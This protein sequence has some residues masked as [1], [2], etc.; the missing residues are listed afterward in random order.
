MDDESFINFQTFLKSRH[1]K[2][3][4]AFFYEELLQETPNMNMEESENHMI[5]NVLSVFGVLSEKERK[6]RGPNRNRELKKIQ[7]DDLYRRR[8]RDEEE[9]IE[10]FRIKRETFDL[11]L[12]SLYDDL[13]LTP[14]NFLRNPTSPDRQLAA[15]LYRLAHGVTYNVL[16]D[17]FGISKEAGCSF[18]NK[19]VRLIVSHFYDE[20]VKLPETDEE[21]E[22]ELRGFIENYGFPTVGAWDGFHVHVN[23]LEKSNYSFK[24]KYT[25][26]NLAL[27]SYNKRFLYAAVGAPGSTHD[28]RM[29]RECSLFDEVL[30]GG[31]IPDR[32]LTL[33]DYGAI[34][35]V[36]IG[37]SAFPRFS[38]LIKAYNESTRDPQKRYFN[39]MLCSARV[40]SENTYGMLK[41]RWR[42]LCKKAETDPKHLRPIIMAC[43]ALHNICIA[44]CDPCKPRWQLEVQELDLI[45]GSLIREQRPAQSDLNRLKISNWLWM[46]H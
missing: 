4:T 34:P 27:T 6:S 37:D 23:S 33:G 20:Y 21:W 35:L 3:K 8:N 38:W 25:I 2:R 36:T 44:K 15:T 43:I 24:K 26:N 14:T 41:G 9:F 32:K 11:L 5:Q 19:T 40:V 12:D 28:A 10:K 39:K 45:E 17:V 13:L 18:F 46:N 1:G 42:F 29:L 31:V 7:W 22:S 16:E 30:N